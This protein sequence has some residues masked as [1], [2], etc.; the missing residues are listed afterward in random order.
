MSRT[1]AGLFLIAHGLVTLAIWVVK[2]PPVPEGQLAP[3][4]PAHSWIVGDARAFSVAFGAL[5]GIALVVAGVGFL[6]GQTW[7]PQA[8]LLSGGISLL[9]FA[10][11]FTPWWLAGIAISSGLLIS[12]LRAI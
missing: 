7:W 12:G 4:D 8:A 3:P 10:V 5:V 6:T 1:L 11:F 9:L 2:S